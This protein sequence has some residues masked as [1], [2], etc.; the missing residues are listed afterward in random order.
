MLHF[1]EFLFMLVWIGL[2]MLHPVDSF[3]QRFAPLQ[4]PAIEPYLYIMPDTDY[5]P[6]SSTYPRTGTHAYRAQPAPTVTRLAQVS[7][8]RL[9]W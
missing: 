3:E 1:I 5:S 6:F 9:D 4:E 8:A 7:R 2:Q